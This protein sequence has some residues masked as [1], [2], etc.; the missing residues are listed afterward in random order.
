V[1][2]TTT[3]GR[4]VTAETSHPK[5][6]SRNPLTDREVEAKFRGLVARTLGDDRCGQVLARALELE[7]AATLDAL[8]D[9]LVVPRAD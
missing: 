2:V 4:R 6:H 8:F 3:D 7:K 5:G 9:S 1:E